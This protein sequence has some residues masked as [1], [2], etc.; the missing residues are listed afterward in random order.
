LAA[1]LCGSI[2]GAAWAGP[3]ASSDPPIF[4]SREIHAN[5][6][7][8]FHRW[9]AVLARFQRESSRAKAVCQLGVSSGC[10]PAEWAR[11]RSEISGLDLRA[12]VEQVNAAI[13]RHPY[14]ASARNWHQVNY[15]E[16]PFEFIRKNGQCQDYATT[17]F[18]LLRAAGV[19]NDAMRL[20]VVHDIER[21]LDHAVLVVYVE[22]EAL[23][24]DNLN[25]RV[26]RASS[27][28]HYRPYY[29]INETG[30]WLHKPRTPDAF[31][32]LRIAQISIPPN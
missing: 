7:E 1:A 14:V 12:K 31:P 19:P 29:S 28:H 15:W 22:G 25:P 26:V 32:A 10:E 6:I 16:T 27:I 30:W 11:L 4:D 13:N 18:L 3:A 24:L 9:T 20:V 21:D 23:V 2:V 5:N 8:P 17:K